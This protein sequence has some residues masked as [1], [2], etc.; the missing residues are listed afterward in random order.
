MQ[1]PVPDG[2]R[3]VDLHRH[4]AHSGQEVSPTLR[5][6]VDAAFLRVEVAWGIIT[7]IS[8]EGL[9]KGFRKQ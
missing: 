3:Q 1:C 9:T 5:R 2:K 8:S 4:Q 7:S 6:R